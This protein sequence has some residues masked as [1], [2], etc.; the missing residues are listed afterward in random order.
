MTQ[1]PVDS[2]WYRQE[3]LC[4]GFEPRHTLTLTLSHTL[5]L[6][7]PLIFSLTLTLT[8]SNS[9]S[10]LP[11]PS[12][13]HL[14]PRILTLTP[15]PHNLTLTLTLTLAL[16]PTH[17]LSISLTLSLTQFINRAIPSP[18]PFFVPRF[19]MF[20]GRELQKCSCRFGVFEGTVDSELALKS[21]G[22]RLSRVRALPLALWPGEKP[23]S[24][25]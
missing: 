7:L 15:H 13:P 25:R 14:H 17:T 6:T 21:T 5:S 16:A 12:H 4:R 24:L 20:S 19:S 18:A 8:P 11:S 1:W 22:I 3:P 10:K 2:P 9:P 23:E